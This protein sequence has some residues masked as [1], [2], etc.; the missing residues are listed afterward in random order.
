MPILVAGT[1]DADFGHLL[2]L[3]TCRCKQV[4][5]VL[6]KGFELLCAEYSLSYYQ[7]IPNFCFFNISLFFFADD[8][9]KPKSEVCAP[10]IAK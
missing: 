9:R 1:S 10:D 8:L 5:K 2:L 7:E 4:V 6:S 3:S